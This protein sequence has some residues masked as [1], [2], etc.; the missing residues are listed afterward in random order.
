MTFD[1]VYTNYQI[2]ASTRHKKQGYTTI[3]ENF[4][5]H[6]LPYFTGKDI[7]TLTKQD[8]LNWQNDILSKNFSNNFN[9]GLYSNFN[10]FIK[11]C[12]LCDYLKENIVEQVGTFK[13]K[14][15]TK[16]HHVYNIW[17]FRWFRL[18][19]DDF[20]IKQFFNFMY[21][22]GPRPGECMALRFAD[23]DGLTVNITH[24]LQRRGKREL[25]TPKNRFSV[26]KIKISLLTKFRICLLK[27][28]YIKMYGNCC[29][30]YYLF[31]G[32]KPLA[33]TTIDRHKKNAC[34][35]AHIL[36]IT[37]HEFRHSYATRMI[38]KGKP[39]NKVSKSMGHN[40]ISMTLDVYTH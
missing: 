16:E 30:D 32:P 38:N 14:I 28:Y 3:S 23:L 33:P 37:Q 10:C 21:F 2:Y 17:Q 35:K 1:K 4:N 18:H 6:I 40:S 26:R 27:R 15:E 9:L 5:K 8:V 13:N 20:V 34:D 24:N 39:I 25:D 22:Y 19:L 29:N 31:G 36:P 7:K 12:I 11:Y